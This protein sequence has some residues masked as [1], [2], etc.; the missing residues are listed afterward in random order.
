MI[1]NPHFQTTGIKQ[2][3]TVLPLSISFSK[4]LWKDVVWQHLKQATV[5][6]GAG[7]F[8][9]WHAVVQEIIGSF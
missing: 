5:V 6:N 8:S 9:N 1:L 3:Q 7:D 2:Q 4:W